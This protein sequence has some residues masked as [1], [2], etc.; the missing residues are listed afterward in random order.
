MNM[1][2]LLSAVLIVALVSLIPINAFAAPRENFT[3]VSSQA[4]T[5]GRLT[6][7]W[8]EKENF[9]LVE[10]S[11]DNRHF[12]SNFVVNGVIY[13]LEET[14]NENY[15]FVKSEFYEM[16]GSEK[17]YIGT[18]TTQIHKDGNDVTVSVSENDSILDIQTYYM[19]E[20]SM[21]D[22]VPSNGDA[23]VAPFAAVEAQWISQGKAN[24]S[25]NIQRY[26]VA[27]IIVILGTAAG[28]PAAA[29]L[30]SIANIII[31]EQWKTVYWT[32]ETWLYMERCPDWPSYPDWVQ[33]GKYK[34]YTEYYSDSARTNLLGTTSYTG[35]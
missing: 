4:Q 1:K 5:I 10:A 33:A 16:S 7:L 19:P 18:Q 29:G 26:T 14:V 27:S 2:R 17:R 6:D 3:A 12:V 11:D 34:Y 13:Q 23:L 31:M 30:T 28:T 24:G 20:V 32:R 21:A 9:T 15:D 8:L 25:N 22:S 35:G